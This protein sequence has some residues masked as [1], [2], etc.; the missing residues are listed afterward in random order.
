MTKLSAPVN[1]IMCS[2]TASVL[3]V[4]EKYATSV[5]EELSESDS[6]SVSDL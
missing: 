2:A 4:R 3:P 1:L 5:F 6:V